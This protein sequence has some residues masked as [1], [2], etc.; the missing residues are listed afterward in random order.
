MVCTVNCRPPCHPDVLF[1]S[2]ESS[3]KSSVMVVLPALGIRLKKTKLDDADVCRAASSDARSTLG[4]KCRALEPM[5]A[6]HSV[7][8]TVRCMASGGQLVQ[9][10]AP[11]VTQRVVLWGCF[12]KFLTVGIRT[13]SA[14]LEHS[15]LR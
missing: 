15:V 7:T 13:F 1:R 14:A 3:D 6:A 4:S 8:S 12:C 5:K 11:G 10:T 2:L 9:A